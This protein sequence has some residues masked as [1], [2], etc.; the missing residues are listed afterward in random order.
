MP[1]E[2]EFAPASKAVAFRRLDRL[3]VFVYAGEYAAIAKPAVYMKVQARNVDGYVLNAVMVRQTDGRKGNAGDYVDIDE[4][5][6]VIELS[7]KLIISGP[8]TT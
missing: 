1:M 6:K 7:S 5:E 8:A 4:D 3:A 2:V